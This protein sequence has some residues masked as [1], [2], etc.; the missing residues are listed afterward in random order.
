MKK[1]IIFTSLLLSV[2][3]GATTF[4]ACSNDNDNEPSSNPLVGTWRAEIEE[5][6]EWQYWDETFNSDYTCSFLEHNKYDDY[7]HDLAVGTY[8]IING[9]TL[10][11]VTSSDYYNEKDVVSTS[12][13]KITDG[14]KL[15]Y[16]DRNH[17]IIYYKIK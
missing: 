12:R 15:E 2:F 16:L 3:M 5:K 9:N 13:F 11:T 6:G 10:K 4:V 8:E 17:G 1:N 14:D 7:V